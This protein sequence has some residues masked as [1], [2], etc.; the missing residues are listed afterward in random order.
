MSAPDMGSMAVTNALNPAETTTSDVPNQIPT[1]DAPTQTAPDPAVQAANAPEPP[2]AAKPSLWRGVLAGA[3]QGLAAGSAVNTKGMGNGGAF[4]AGAGAGANQVLNKVPA[5][6]AELDQAK[7]TTAIHYANLAKIQR[8]LNLMPD[9]RREQRVDDAIDHSEAMFKSG[10]MVPLSDVSKDPA[11]AQKA[12]MGLH[13]KNPWAVYSIAP[14]RDS[15]G[16]AAY[17]VVQFGKAPIQEDLKLPGMGPD[18][19]DLVIPAGTPGETVGKIYSQAFGKNMDAAAKKAL[20]TQKEGGRSDLET[21]KQAGRVQIKQMG[22]DAATQKEVTKAKDM[23]WGTN[24]E[25]EQVA[26][27]AD[28]LKAAGV[29]NAVKLPGTETQKVVVARQLIGPR[30]GL[31]DRVNADIDALSKSGKLGVIQSRWGDFMAGKIGS[32]PEFQA[33]RTHMGLLSTALMQAHVGARGSKDMLQHFKELAD[34]SISDEATLRKALQSEW[35]YVNEKA[36]L[37]T[38][39]PLKGRTGPGQAQAAPAAGGVKHIFASAPGKPR[40]QS[41]DGGKTW[42]PVR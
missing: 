37:P 2:P 42:Q 9:S 36:M 27:S 6:N 32:E 16:D 28:E 40:M 18:G 41:L 14:V 21:Q 1:P 5:Q 8:D 15:N 7:A 24:A 39:N 25:G 4:A 19:K 20:E 34:Y 10:A 33:L 17:Q 30:K 29:T 31:F 22:L 11:D 12:L 13:A 26:G 35:E 23:V 3:L 38:G